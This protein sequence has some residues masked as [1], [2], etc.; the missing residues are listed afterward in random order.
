MEQHYDLLSHPRTNFAAWQSQQRELW[1]SAYRLYSD[2]GLEGFLVTDEQWAA[3]PGNTITTEAIDDEPAVVTIAARPQFETLP[4][5]QLNATA[6][7]TANYDRT[8]KQQKL[9]R[10][11]YDIL[12]KNLISTINPHD[13]AVLR[14]P[15]HAL[16][17]VTAKAIFAHIIV[18]HGTLDNADYVQLLGTLNNTMTATDTVSSIVATHRL[19]HQQLAAAQQPINNY[20]QCFY[21][22][23]ATAHN[24]QVVKAINSYLVSVPAIAQQTFDALTTYVVQQTPNF[25]PTAASMGYTATA[26]AVTTEDA[27]LASPAFAAL[28]QRA[29]QLA[30]PTGQRSAPSGTQ[31]PPTH[32]CY[33]HGHNTS[34][35]GT[36]CTVMLANPERY[37]PSHLAAT[38]P[39][40][41]P[42]GSTARGG[43]WNKNNRS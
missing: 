22:K 6:A 39:T 4:Q 13:L 41:V 20:Q 28:L 38:T 1:G 34:H 24:I 43:R 11:Q 19:V 12:K 31:K 30:L 14:H 2:T 35:H 17:H 23:A 15:Q 25:I 5:L 27:I 18:L 3:I 37:L 42:N 16:L 32:Y 8:L 40:A 33:H 9:M 26:T 21:F 7:V 29:I 36:T 10:E